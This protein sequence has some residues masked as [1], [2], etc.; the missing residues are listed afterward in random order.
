MSSIKSHSFHGRRLVQ[1]VLALLLSFWVY[2]QEN[3]DRANELSNKLKKTT[4]VHE[5][6]TIR[7]QIEELKYNMNLKLWKS[8]AKEAHEIV[9][10]EAEGKCLNNIGF[11]LSNEGK[12]DEAI[13]YYHRALDIYRKAKSKQGLAGVYNDLG[14]IYS[15]INES[16]KAVEYYN[17]S[18]DLY[19]EIADSLGMSMTAHNLSAQYFKAKK[20]EKALNFARK[21]YELANRLNDL[22][23][24]PSVLQNL[25]SILED[26][27]NYDSAF[28]MYQ[29]G[30]QISAK[31]GMVHGVAYTG[32]SLGGMYLDRYKENNSHR[33]F[34]DSA[35]N[36]FLNSYRIGVQ[37]KNA[38]VRK[39]ASMHLM[40]YYT[41][42][43]N[44]EKA[45]FYTERYYTLKDTLDNAE[46]QKEILRDHMEYEHSIEKVKA[47][48]ERK[49]EKVLAEEKAKRL[50]FI[51]LGAGLVVVTLIIFSVLIVRKWKQTQHQK[52]I[53]EHQ[54][55]LV[56][57]KQKE[58]IDSINYAKHLQQ[59]ILATPEE[60]KK[61][62]PDTFLIY[63]PK[64]IVAGDFYFFETTKTHIFIAAADCTGHGVPGALVSVVCS[65]ALSR[66]VKEFNLT[67]PGKILDKARELILETFM[68]SGSDV[69]DG[70]DI[71]LCSVKFQ[72]SDDGFRNK[73]EKVSEMSLQWAGA[74]NP[75]WVIS[76]SATKENRLTEIKADKQPI[77]KSDNSHPFATHEVE[78]EKGDLIVLF[79][80]GFAD[81]FGGSEGKKFKYSNLKKL[82]IENAHVK[83]QAIDLTLQTT[84]NRWKGDLEQVDDVCIIGIR[85]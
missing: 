38:D 80:D 41:F 25:G 23:G 55:E 70:M 51:I 22:Q 67:E 31:I 1:L 54:K 52:I 63:M 58:I 75:L 4:D 45:Q 42:I 36:Y 76:Q 46:K 35:E 62:L 83:P 13:G 21:S 30:Y 7:I 49:A 43:K 57:E 39:R 59:A 68:K 40:R 60:I 50:F 17:K 69:K 72:N 15:D 71:S 5:K 26:Q 82:L 29:K 84:F 74:N 61:Y 79:T 27:G 10:P 11:I 24:L 9:H 14:G 56:E 78:Y 53:I 81:Q 3:N 85:L 20:P 8:M 12:Q 16:R 65:N 64:D 44:W 47:A 18:Y 34:L 48:Q 37:V 32:M 19:S 28:I 6:L 33:N 2:A 73:V 77:G 66:C